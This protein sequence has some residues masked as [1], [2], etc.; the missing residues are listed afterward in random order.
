VAGRDRNSDAPPVAVYETGG[1]KFFPNRCRHASLIGPPDS[2]VR[3]RSRSSVRRNKLILSIVAAIISNALSAPV[4]SAVLPAYA[5]ANFGS[6]VAL[7][8]M[9]EAVVFGA[10]GHRLPPHPWAWCRPPARVPGSPAPLGGDR[11]LLPAG[12]ARHAAQ[13]GAR[14]C[15]RPV[16]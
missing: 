1:G 12:D 9:V 16:A 11:R 5:D 10:V 3:G 15:G 14:G 8:R 2:P 4:S 7:G 13:P 6:A